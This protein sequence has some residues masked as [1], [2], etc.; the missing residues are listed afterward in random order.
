ML[1]S[2]NLISLIFHD[3][4]S[5]FKFGTILV[6]LLCT[7]SIILM[8]FLRCGAQMTFEYSIIGLTRV[9]YSRVI[10]FSS[11]KSNDLLIMLSI[12]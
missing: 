7:A 8:C 9:E 10:M 12:C 1:V 11:I 2:I 5:F 6:A 4:L 3:S